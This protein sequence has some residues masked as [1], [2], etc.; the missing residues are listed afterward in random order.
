MISSAQSIHRRVHEHILGLAPRTVFTPLEL[1]GET[2]GSAVA[3]RQALCRLCHDGIIA[4]MRKGYYQRLPVVNRSVAPPSV[5]DF[6][7]AFARKVVHR[8]VRKKQLLL[9]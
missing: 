1:I 4:R 2:R 6:A 9:K 3:V 7:Y 8:R 5:Q